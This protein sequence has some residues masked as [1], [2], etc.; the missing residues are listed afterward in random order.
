[1]LRYFRHIRKRLIMT[2]NVR[3]YL[4]YAIG[5]ILL[6]VIGIL[7]ALQVNNWNEAR[8]DTRTKD[9]LLQNLLVDI[10]ADLVSME[11]LHEQL[12][13]R[14]A[15]ADYLLSIIENPELPVDTLQTA[16]A[17]SRVGWV[18]TYTPTFATY[19]EIMSSGRLSLIESV[20][21][22]KGLADYKSTVEDSRRI[23]E[24][25]NKGLKEVELL[26]ATFLERI[27]DGS[28]KFSGIPEEYGVIG[29]H[30][31]TMLESERFTELLKHISFH[32]SQSI[33]YGS[34]FIIPRAE[35]VKEFLV[36]EIAE[37]L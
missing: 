17:L 6:V 15:Q 29:V 2:D 36:E 4:L 30:F 13:D 1:M 12:S 27:P 10:E 24:T 14:I 37:N 22:K 23:A 16:V 33:N 32:T 5:E 8:K 9:I 7:I 31:D 11:I 28:N 20:E 35:R 21:L 26:S 18:L 25:Y 34:R 3:K 19:N